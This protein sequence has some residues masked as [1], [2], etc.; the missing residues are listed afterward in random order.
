MRAALVKEAWLLWM[1]QHASSSFN[2]DPACYMI[3]NPG[4][5]LSHIT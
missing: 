1:V 4:S 2:V 5:Y 3:I